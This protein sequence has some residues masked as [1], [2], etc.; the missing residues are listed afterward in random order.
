MTGCNS[1]SHLKEPV[2][3]WPV[4][5]KRQASF[6][7]VE[8]GTR[9][10]GVHSIDETQ[11]HRRRFGN[12]GRPVDIWCVNLRALTDCD[13]DVSEESQKVNGLF[14]MNGD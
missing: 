7:R 5:R 9:E 10:S 12:G 13:T 14:Y 6:L 8:L 3:S 4:R 11:N 1:W 2:A